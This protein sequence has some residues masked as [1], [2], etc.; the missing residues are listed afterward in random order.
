MKYTPKQIGEL[1]KLVRKQMGATQKD[2]A[3][4]SGTGLRFIIE[5][6][7]GKPTCQIGKVLTVLNTLGITMTFTPPVAVQKAA[8]PE[9]K[10]GN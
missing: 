10:K 5:L 4:T 9:P 1:V 6:E 3:L 2:L 8:V 7:Q